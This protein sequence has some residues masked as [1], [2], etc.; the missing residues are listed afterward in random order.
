MDDRE[1]SCFKSLIKHA[2]LVVS[3]NNEIL[4]ATGGKFNI[5]RVS[6]VAHYETIHSSV[7]AE[8]LNPHGSHGMHEKFLDAFL[9]EIS[10]KPCIIPACCTVRTES[11]FD[12]GRIDI[13]IEDDKNG[14]IFIENKIYAADGHQQLV[15]YSEILKT[16]SRSQLYYLTL[17]GDDAEDYSAMKN[18]DERVEY[19]RLSYRAH[20]L[21]W[22]ARCIQI[23][24]E[25]PLVRET[26]RQYRNH[27]KEILGMNSDKELQ[28]LSELICHDRESYVAAG[29]IVSSW[30]AVKGGVL[31]KYIAPQI[32]EVFMA[33][34]NKYNL[35]AVPSVDS[36]TSATYSGFDIRLQ[37]K[38]HYMAFE[39]EAGG[40]RNLIYGIVKPQASKLCSFKEHPKGF[41]Y[42]D[43]W[44]CWRYLPKFRDW[45]DDFFLNMMFDKSKQDEFKAT[46]ATCL[47]ELLPL[48]NQL[49]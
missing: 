43:V 11:V 28:D 18:N 1:L 7:I 47:E 9:M 32:K 20:V 10:D 38:E 48:I 45:G 15:R 39:F 19:T 12:E 30:G 13:V 16:K 29:K 21:N 14:C 4:E 8:F 3:K 36:I 49:S 41:N 22:L 35:I 24:S 33:F 6:G 34:A 42:S 46:I 27:L 25:Y 17:N 2:K 5:F 26:L 31:K 37:G 23:A 40:F 44:S